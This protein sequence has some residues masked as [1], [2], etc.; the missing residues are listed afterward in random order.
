MGASNQMKIARMIA[1]ALLAAN[2]TPANAGCVGRDDLLALRTAAIQQELMVA[3]LT[4]R[5][6]ARYNR[7]VVSH[8]PELVYSDNR[9]KSFFVQR[10]ARRS[11]AR[12]HSFK[13]ELANTASL[14]S[15]RRAESFCAR[16]EAAFDLAE[17]SSSLVDFVSA[18][19]IAVGRAYHGC[20][21]A[22]ADMPIL[23][24]TTRIRRHV[25]RR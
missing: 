17:Q 18:E 6:V 21:G 20:R 1:A 24:E 4:C 7:F 8:Q 2:C 5:D 13:T 14:R 25:H 16:A 22:G 15:A 9:L 23:V 19:P 12:Y 3:A 10:S 11:E